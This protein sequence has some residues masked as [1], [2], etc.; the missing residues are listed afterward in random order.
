[1]NRDSNKYQDRELLSPTN[2]LFIP[3]K[4]GAT[5]TGCPAKVICAFALK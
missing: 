1:M 5:H 2:I 4:E 3:G